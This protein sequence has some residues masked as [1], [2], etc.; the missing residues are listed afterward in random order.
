MNNQISHRRFVYAFYQQ[1]IE[2][3]KNVNNLIYHEDISKELCEA[4]LKEK[5]EASVSRISM[6]KIT[7]FLNRIHVNIEKNLSVTFRDNRY[8]LLIQDNAIDMFFVYL[9]K[10]KDEILKQLHAFKR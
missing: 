7:K 8:F 5:Q 3:K 1:I 2:N 9:M 4:Y 10:T 6:R